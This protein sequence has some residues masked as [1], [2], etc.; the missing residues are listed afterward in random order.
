MTSVEFNKKWSKYLEEGFYGMAINH[1]NIIEYLDVEFT[2][3]IETNPLFNYAQIKTKFGVV[4]IYSN[5]EKN[6][7]WEKEANRLIN[8]S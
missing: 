3:E 2:K 4:V 6:A 5:S 8:I 7:I 1:S